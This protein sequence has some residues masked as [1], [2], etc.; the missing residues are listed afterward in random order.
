MKGKLK[1]ENLSEEQKNFLQTATFHYL[2][3][4]GKVGVAEEL[5]L[6]VYHFVEAELHKGYFNKNASCK[7]GCSFCCHLHVEISR[8]EGK[9]LA[10]FVNS[11]QREI[12][13]KQAVSQSIEDWSKLSY[14][15]R[16]CVFL[17][18]G[19]CSVYD[20]R[21]LACRKYLVA[22]A[23]DLCN[24]ETSFNDVDTMVD[25]NVEAISTAFYFVDG[26]KSMAN[27]VLK[28]VIV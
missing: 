23:P 26:C 20:E 2:N 13:V 9:N 7:R 4:L 17:K 14:A 27:E 28:Y 22:S 18:N 5:L 24:T 6:E 1:F 16:K 10:R 12:L 21:P 3:E 11:E 19:E 8:T 15:D 25:L